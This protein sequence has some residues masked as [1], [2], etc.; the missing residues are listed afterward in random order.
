MK[1]GTNPIRPRCRFITSQTWLFI[2]A[3]ITR[4][5]GGETA[6]TSEL[7]T[8][9]AQESYVVD[10]VSLV[11]TQKVGEVTVKLRS[12]TRPEEV[13][14]GVT[15]GNATQFKRDRVLS[16]GLGMFTLQSGGAVNES[17]SQA[18]ID[19]LNQDESIEYCYPAYVDAATGFRHLI[20]SEIVVRLQAPADTAFTGALAPLKLRVGEML[21]SEPPLYVLHLTEP[22]NFNPFRVCEAIRQ[23]PGVVWAEPNMAQEGQELVIPNDTYFADQWH[24]R[25]TGQYGAFSDA[26]VDAD[27]AWDASQG[28]GSP[29]IRIAVLDVGVQTDHP[30]LQANIVAGYDF[31]GNDADPGPGVALDN[32]GTPVAGAAAA[33][34][35]NSLGVAGVA[36]KCKILPVRVA[37]TLDAA[38]HIQLTD[39][40]SMYRAVVYAADN[41]DVISI[42]W[43]TSYNGTIVSAL[44]HAYIYGRAGKGCVTLCAAGN[45]AG[46][47]GDNSYGGSRR[48]LDLYRDLGGAGNYYVYFVYVK[49]ASGNA[50]DDCFWL[51]DFVLPNGTSERL[52]NGTLPAGWQTAG[53]ANW[54]GAV[55]PVHA[56]GTTRHAW[57]SGA[58]GDS[59]ISGLLTPLLTIDSNQTT[60]A[61]RNWISSDNG[62]IAWAEV[63][64]SSFVYLGRYYLGQGAADNRVT[65][66]AFPANNYYVFGIGAST[67]FDYRSHFS[68]YGSPLDFVA[69][70]GGGYAGIVTTDRTGASGYDP[71][72][73]YVGLEGTSFSA[74][75]AAGIAALV[76]SR[77]G[78]QTRA[79]VANK[80]VQ[81][82]DKV[83]PV[84]Y[85]GSPSR[86]DYYGYGR[87]NA[88][89]S[90]NATTADTTPPTW[91]GV[92]V[93]NHRAVD[94]EFSEPMGEGATDPSRYSITAGAG[95]LS[96]NPAKVIRIR[97]TTYRLLWT[98]GD[99]APSGYVTIALSSTIKDVAGNG[100]TGSLSR[101]PFGTKRIIAINCGNR[102]DV[103]GSPD[104]L[105]YT[106]PF[107]SDSGFQGNEPA[108]YLTSSP[109]PIVYSSTWPI[110]GEVWAPM[111]VYQTIR[112]RWYNSAPITYVIL[113]P[114]VLPGQTYKVRLHFAE[115]YFSGVEFTGYQVFDIKIQ[116]VVK[117]A[118][119]DILAYT[120]AN[121][122]AC[123][124]EYSGILPDTNGNIKVEV[125]PQMGID[126]QYRAV[127]NGIE[128][129]RP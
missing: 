96:P 7:K 87:L 85:T 73:D 101:S 129:L 38:G 34:V 45:S 90:V 125:V 44:S 95:T 82:C 66:V 103:S 42:S 25:N 3:L 81:N 75:A 116:D 39:N 52:D 31:Y 27:I 55:D 123:V 83:G 91:Q 121:L 50:N 112:A 48:S 65:A 127:I 63:Y 60:L 94:I 62:D 57:R 86:N 40:A 41:A 46:G 92:V 9:N 47:E 105:Y 15:A 20:Y 72:A 122:T 2:A 109:V 113:V 106:P 8:F 108:P 88:N 115:I 12:A 120:G 4:G 93:M 117:T 24:V 5:T 6:Q 58:V 110:S 107:V 78:N 33:A 43:G 26:D 22:K 28:Y 21:S 97:P 119:F 118:Y 56:H 71:N 23:H 79:T 30:D 32:H 54:T 80:L 68:Q 61:F 11:L 29:G 18:A 13:A 102:G 16:R 36:G 51:A 59:Q 1:E 126:G 100:L 89:A 114:P 49:D 17:A 69:P 70:G 98:S 35:N 76:L 104:G 111:E 77:D 84:A 64:N 14:E 10:G 53:D 74:P 19:S 99:M 128:I 67:D 124:L 37:L